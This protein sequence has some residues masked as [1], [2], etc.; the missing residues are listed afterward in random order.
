MTSMIMRRFVPAAFFL[1][2]VA[3]LGAT[4]ALAAG[5]SVV[6]KPT[7]VEPGASGRATLS[8]VQRPYPPSLAQ[9]KGLLVVQC[10]GLTPNATYSVYGT[11]M[12]GVASEAGTLSLSGSIYFSGSQISVGVYNAEG[13][14]L[15]GTIHVRFK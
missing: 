7:G 2:G 13:R 11:H 15:T 9:F 1:M 3:L 6:L 8:N 4:P 14:V 5:G 10:K 12:V